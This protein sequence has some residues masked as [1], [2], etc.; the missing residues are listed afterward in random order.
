MSV[1]FPPNGAARRTPETPQTQADALTTQ[2]IQG[3]VAYVAAWND[4]WMRAG[5]DSV[6]KFAAF[7]ASPLGVPDR[8]DTAMNMFLVNGSVR[9][10]A[11][12]P[13]QNGAAT[14]IKANKDV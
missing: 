13:G 3:P 11:L 8:V 4:Y 12:V 10:P 7:M 9:K 5:T 14:W 2:A 1:E 6:S